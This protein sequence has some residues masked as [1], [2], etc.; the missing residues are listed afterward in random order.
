VKFIAR[1]KRR[2]AGI[3]LAR[4]R[5]HR[6]PRRRENGYVGRSNNVPIRIKQH[7]GQDSRHKPKGWSDLDPRWKVLWLPWWASWKWV[8]APLEFLAIRLL[9]PRYN[10]QHNLGNP[11]RVSLHLQAIQR[12]QRDNLRRHGMT[13]VQPSSA[14]P[15]LLTLGSALIIL[16]LVMTV[17]SNR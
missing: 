16:G 10:H 5:K 8:Q 2:K 1:A 15:I 17:W 7:M 14:R 11:R 3:Y 12:R 9:L 6:N 13:L 4:T